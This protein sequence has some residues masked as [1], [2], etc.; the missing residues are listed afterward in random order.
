MYV[1][2]YAAEIMFPTWVGRSNMI[3]KSFETIPDRVFAFDQRYVGFFIVAE[4]SVRI[5]L[6]VSSFRFQTL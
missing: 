6:S 4:I 3:M 1:L 2:P 5:A